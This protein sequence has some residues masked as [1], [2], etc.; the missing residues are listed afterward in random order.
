M[1]NL[2]IPETMIDRLGHLLAESPLDEKIK[3]AILDN[4]DKIPGHMMVG[5]LDAL[6]A[7][8]EQLKNLE[9]DLKSFEEEQDNKG[10]ELEA[11]KKAVVESMAQKWAQKIVEQ[12]K[13]EVIKLDI[14]K[15]D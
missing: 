4:L 6:N 12:Y 13:L 2:S 15:T 1:N 7:E 9:F 3:Q 5:L 11:K 8:R 10:G 14:S